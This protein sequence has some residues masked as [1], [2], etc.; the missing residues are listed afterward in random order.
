MKL[1]QMSR[2]HSPEREEEDNVVNESELR[3]SEQYI[4]ELEA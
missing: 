3:E 1:M 2:D 4:N